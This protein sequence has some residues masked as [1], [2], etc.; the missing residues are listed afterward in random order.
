LRVIS[1]PPRS[2][3]GF[4]GDFDLVFP[5]LY[6]PPSIRGA[7]DLGIEPRFTSVET[8]DYHLITSS[9]AIDT[10]DDG[11]DSALRNA[12]RLRTTTGVEPDSDQ[13]DLGYHF[14]E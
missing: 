8:D 13:L 9:P 4:D 6:D 3:V 12:L 5:P 11:I 10:G 7:H 14:R 2:D 1:D